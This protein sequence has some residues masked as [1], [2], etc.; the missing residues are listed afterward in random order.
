MNQEFCEEIITYLDPIQE[1]EK[2]AK[3]FPVVK[4]HDIN[5]A[6]RKIAD[7]SGNGFHT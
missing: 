7:K 5:F 1:Q 3:D 4:F 2:L 6:A